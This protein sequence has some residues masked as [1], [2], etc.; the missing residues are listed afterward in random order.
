VASYINHFQADTDY[1][2]LVDLL[3]GMPILLLTI[4]VL[5]RGQPV[6]IAPR[7]SHQAA[8]IVRAGSPLMLAA[9]LLAI[10]CLLVDERPAIAVGGFL[11]AALGMGLRNIFVQTRSFED[12][13]RLHALARVD[14][15]TGLANRR[16][17]D[18]VLRSEW[19]RTVREGGSLALLMIDVDRFKILN[20]TFGHPVGD[21]RLREVGKTLASCAT[22]GGDLVARYGGEEFAVILANT[23]PAEAYALADAM[24]LAI[25]GLRPPSPVP[26]GVV[27]ISIG[28][29]YADL[30]E[31]TDPTPLLRI[32]DAALYAAKSGGRDRIASEAC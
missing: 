25:S 17:F 1:G 27:T 3:I 28:V 5:R 10:S 29:G 2:T 14:A 15:L 16:Q 32:A 8:H 6:G 23:G 21:E 9:S 31:G 7:R 20:D 11:V 13:D 24:R 4:L 18:D 12:N 30:P 26:G 22:R 19:R